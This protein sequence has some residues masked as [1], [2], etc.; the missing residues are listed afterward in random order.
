M[1]TGFNVG[2]LGLLAN[3]RRCSELYWLTLKLNM[4][5]SASADTTANVQWMAHAKDK[6]GVQISM[7]PSITGKA[8]E[9]QIDVHRLT[10]TQNRVENPQT[11][12]IQLTYF[13]SVM[14]NQ[15]SSLSI[16]IA[17][18]TEKISV[19]TTPNVVM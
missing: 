17:M 6:E 7:V 15:V 5:M 13:G 11:S 9:V 10:D 14:K 8:K 12:L 18:R 1:T 2:G 16:L 3:S 19:K 4:Y